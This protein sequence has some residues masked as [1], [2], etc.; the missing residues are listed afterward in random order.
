MT[1]P[2]KHWQKQIIMINLPNCKKVH[3]QKTKYTVPK[4]KGNAQLY[5]KIHAAISNTSRSAQKNIVK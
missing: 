3:K 2:K 1:V 5:L 4:C